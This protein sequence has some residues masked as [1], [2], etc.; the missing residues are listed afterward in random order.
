MKSLIIKY[1]KGKTNT[2]EEEELYN[3][4]LKDDSNIQ[5]FKKEIVFIC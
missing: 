2:L 4:L 3:W 5:I 1:L